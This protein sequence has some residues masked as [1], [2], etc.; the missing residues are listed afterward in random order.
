LARDLRWALTHA[1]LHLVYQPVVDM[2]DNRL[3]GAEALVRWRHP[4]RGNV[5]AN[6]LVDVAEEF[7]LIDDLGQWLVEE[8][9][10]T[11]SSWSDLMNN[12]SV[13]INASPIEIQHA[14]YA[15]RLADAMRR[16]GIRSEQLAVEITESTAIEDNRTTQL[17]LKALRNAGIM[18]CI[19]DFGVGMSSLHRLHAT[20]ANRVKI[21]RYFVEGIT[22]DAGRRTTIE[23]II[24][25]AESLQLDV[26]CEGV[27]R[28]EHVD[29]LV[30]HGLHKAQ[31]YYY[32]QP[33]AE[34]AMRH[35]LEV[36]YVRGQTPLH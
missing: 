20:L 23:M 24:K 9:L 18:V 34:D 15:Q 31:G 17:N 33:V 8:A 16:H 12:R 35:L 7:G 32:P 6:L 36:G 14:D 5:P 4:A 2:R 22:E 1:G 27:S 10:R 13:S 19:D 29:F 21:D 3:L 11:M 28:A 30:G 25:L 26:V